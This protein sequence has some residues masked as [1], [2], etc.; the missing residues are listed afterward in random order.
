MSNEHFTMGNT[1]GYMGGELAELNRRFEAA[2]AA[3]DFSAMEDWERWEICQE[4]GREILVAYDR[5]G[6]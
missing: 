1:E 3:Y 5:E 6:H 2:I 4:V